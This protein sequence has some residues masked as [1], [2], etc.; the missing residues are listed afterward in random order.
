MV[1]GGNTPAV[2][3]M[4]PVYIFQFQILITDMPPAFTSFP[5]PPPCLGI[6]T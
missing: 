1:G 6:D 5:Y 2:C 3:K 4:I